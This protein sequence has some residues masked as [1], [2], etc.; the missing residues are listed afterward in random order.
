VSLQANIPAARRSPGRGSPQSEAAAAA[1]KPSSPAERADR[2]AWLCADRLV[3]AER[4]GGSLR[5][6]MP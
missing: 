4:Y 5:E 6:A 1:L 2:R 3:R